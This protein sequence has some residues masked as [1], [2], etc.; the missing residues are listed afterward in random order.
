[1]SLWLVTIVLSWAVGLKGPMS[2]KVA[3]AIA[4]VAF[5]AGAVLSFGVPKLADLAQ[6]HPP[7]ARAGIPTGDGG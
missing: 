2:K 7:T 3:A 6:D 5:V 1:V 4:V